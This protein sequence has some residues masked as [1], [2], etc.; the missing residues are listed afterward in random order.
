[1][2][3]ISLSL[4]SREEFHSAL[5]NLSTAD[6]SSLEYA[7]DRQN[8]LTKPQGSLGKLEELSIFMAGWQARQKPSLNKVTC[9]VFAGNHGI[10]R[11]G[12]SAYPPEVTHQMV[13][14]FETGGAAINQLCALAQADLKV[15]A[16]DL[17]KPTND[18]SEEPA[19]SEDDLCQAL[20][21]GANAVPV[22]A[23]CILLGEMGIGNS[24]SAA[25]LSHALFGGDAEQWVG[26]GTGLDPDKMAHKTQIVAN[27]VRHHQQDIRDS[28][29]LLRCLGGRELAAISG[30]V[31]AARHHRIPVLLDGFISTAAAATLTKT[32]PDILD[33]CQL[34]HLSVE[35]G[36]HH[37]A[38]A[39]GKDP[40]LHLNMR[41]GEA[42]GAAVALMILRASLVTYNGMAS[43]EEAQ[44]SQSMEPS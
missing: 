15:I 6:Q 31:L 44:V 33:H 3:K 28:F 19:L 22:D 29:D 25:A 13:Q 34:S 9:L 2:N 5:S 8:S 10:T 4:G 32:A 1:M 40:I 43:F 35:P 21:T 18:F 39:L 7:R 38:K 37:L 11:Q 23:D 26:R 16:L 17:D 41:L 27:A 20:Q 24:T 12:I 36:H 42:S 30:A 14:N